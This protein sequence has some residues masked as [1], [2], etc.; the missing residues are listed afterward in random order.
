[1][2][3][4]RVDVQE[5]SRQPARKD[6]RAREYLLLDRREGP[7]RFA[8]AELLRDVRVLAEQQ[9][10]FGDQREKQRD[11]GHAN[12]RRSVPTTANTTARTPASN[13]IELAASFRR[14]SDF[15]NNAR[16]RG[17]FQKLFTR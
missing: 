2:Q 11:A 1:M 14:S 3:L 8:V 7:H 13:A 16:S 15:S 6:E 4:V 5:R 17:Q 9:Q 10:I 12:R